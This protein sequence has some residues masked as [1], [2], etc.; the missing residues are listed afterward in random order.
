M[1]E[2]RSVVIASLIANASIAVMKFVGFLL[3]GSAAML[4]ETYQSISDTGNQIFLLIGI[5]YSKQR[6]DRDHPFGYGKAQF[7]YSFLVSVLLFGVAGIESARKGYETLVGGGSFEVSNATIPVIGVTLSGAEIS[8]LVLTFAILFEAWAL[9]KAYDGMQAQI[10][11][12]DWSGLREAFRKTSDVTTLTAL[13]EDAIALAGAA[14]G[15]VGIYLTDTTGNHIYDGIAALLIGLLLMGFA[16]ALAWQNKRLL[17]GES[18]P[19]DDE[20]R[21]R[22]LVAGFDGVER[23]VDFRTVYFGPEE[24]IVA[25]DVAFDSGLDARTIGERIRAI[26]NALLEDDSQVRNAY[27]EPE[28]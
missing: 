11:E 16:V 19:A 27:I 13:T 26:N 5:R 22:E 28:T 15:M 6:A 2:S 4:S 12:H 23:I 25:A 17:L 21:L 18:L 10:E 9:K 7:F 24:V 14:I 8:Y 3:T 1:A 20:R